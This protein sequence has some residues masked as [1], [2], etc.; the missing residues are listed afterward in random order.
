MRAQA[1]FSVCTYKGT[2]T[3]ENLDPGIAEML[4]SWAPPDSSSLTVVAVLGSSL[5]PDTLL[6][7]WMRDTDPRHTSSSV[8]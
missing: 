5:F 2:S 3:I 7:S 4:V 8:F 1:L 6:S